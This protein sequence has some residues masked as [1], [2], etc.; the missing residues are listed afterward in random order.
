MEPGLHEKVFS[1]EEAVTAFKVPYAG[2]NIFFFLGSE[3]GPHSQI[4]GLAPPGYPAMYRWHHGSPTP[5]DIACGRGYLEESSNVL[6][7][8]GSAMTP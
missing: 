3:K 4:S 2:Q 1:A 7:V 8:T 5:L 6:L